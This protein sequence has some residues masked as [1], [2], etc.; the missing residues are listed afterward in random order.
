MALGLLCC[1]DILTSKIHGGVQGPGEMSLLLVN[2]PV[3]GI[4]TLDV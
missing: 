1:T 2:V 4:R 3:C